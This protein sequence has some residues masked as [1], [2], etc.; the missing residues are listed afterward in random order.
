MTTKTKTRVKAK[1]KAK[2]STHPTST[3]RQMAPLPLPLR[4][5]AKVRTGMGH[6]LAMANVSTIHSP[7][8]P[9]QLRHSAAA[10]KM[11]P[12]NQPSAKMKP[13]SSWK[14]SS[15]AMA[16]A[17]RV[18]VTSSVS[19]SKTSKA[20]PKKQLKST[21]AKS[22]RSSSGLNTPLASSTTAHPAVMG[23]VRMSS[24]LLAVPVQRPRVFA[25][26]IHQDR[27]VMPSA[28]LHSRIS[29]KSCPC[30]LSPRSPL[31]NA[32]L[33]FVRL[34]NIVPRTFRSATSRD[35][36]AGATQTWL[37]HSAGPSNAVANTTGS[38]L[39]PTWSGAGGQPQI[40]ASLPSGSIHVPVCTAAIHTAGGTSSRSASSSTFTQLKW[41]SNQILGG[42]SEFRISPA[43]A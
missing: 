40:P 43:Q 35:G 12:R 31:S 9:I 39:Y 38:S 22:W 5:M 14:F 42:L 41:R 21:G 36:R 2:A 26:S 11:P 3:T 8:C 15:A 17:Q 25:S 30:S 27:W 32:I 20:T 37:Q 24:Y 7:T 6:P 28:T 29:V 1:V 33:V 13:S 34:G 19:T 18:L 4:K 16:M 23:I 10:S